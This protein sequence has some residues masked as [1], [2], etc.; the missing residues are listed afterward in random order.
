MRPVSIPGGI[1]HLNESKAVCPHCGRSISFEEID[2]QV[3]FDAR[4][5]GTLAC[6]CKR[7]I[8]ITQDMMGDYVAFRKSK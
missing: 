2:K 6:K 7:R 4:G 8:G 3:K 1:L 5:Y